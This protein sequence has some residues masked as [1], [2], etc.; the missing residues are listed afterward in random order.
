MY[1]NIAPNIG[2][3]NCRIDHLIGATAIQ[4]KMQLLYWLT[5]ETDIPEGM[6]WMNIYVN[7]LHILSILM[8]QVLCEWIT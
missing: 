1:N 6:G 8:G 5:K 4:Q 2:V 3:Y 7:E